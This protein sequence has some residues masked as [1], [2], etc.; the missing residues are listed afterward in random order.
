MQDSATDFFAGN[1]AT[2]YDARNARL[3]PISDAL[4][5]LTGL[6]LEDLPE[7]ARLL[8]VGTGTGAEVLALARAHPGW[9]FTCVDPS[10]DMLAVC[11]DRLAQAGLSDRCTL[12]HGDV[13]ALPDGAPH[14]AALAMLVAHFIAEG[15]R[16]DFYAAIRAHLS[17]G[18]PFV[19]AEISH[20]LDAP[21]FAPTLGT[22]K[23]VQTLMGATP[24]SLDRLPIL[25]RET[26]AV[27]S[28]ARTD[29][30]LAEAGF[31]A[32]TTFYQ[33]VMIRALHA[34]A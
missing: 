18:A 23:Q 14:D 22:W 27:L 24:E 13:H 30:L 25:L 3:A 6:V 32:P 33:A 12:V 5:F 16:P 31:T 4:H 34:R 7:D 17:P 26:L 1:A 9:R 10:A 21:S 28:P 29:A 15:D 8:S 20:D 2:G 11:A 19:S